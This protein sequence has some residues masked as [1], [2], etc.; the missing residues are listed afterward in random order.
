MLKFNTNTMT[1]MSIVGSCGIEQTFR[2][3]LSSILIP[4]PLFHLRR[5]LLEALIADDSLLECRHRRPEGRA[6]GLAGQPEP[7]VPG[8][9]ALVWPALAL[10]LCEALWAPDGAS[11]LPTH[12][13]GVL[14]L[15]Y[16]RDEL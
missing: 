6:V 13:A 7:G 4:T 2:S 9:E 12:G 5:Q 11:D 14:W 3:G 8:A 10:D 16:L 1:K 15:C